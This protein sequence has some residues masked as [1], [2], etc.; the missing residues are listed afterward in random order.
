MKGVSKFAGFWGAFGFWVLN[1][2]GGFGFRRRKSPLL[3]LDST[4]FQSFSPAAGHFNL[5]LIVY[6]KNIFTC[7]RL[8]LHFL[9]N[10]MVNTV[11]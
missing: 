9:G 10:D 1:D 2:P 11:K 5:T 3:V 7:S 8:L 6:L 4:N